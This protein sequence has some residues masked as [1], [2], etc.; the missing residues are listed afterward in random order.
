MGRQPSRPP[1]EL[2]KAAAAALSLSGVRGGE[3]GG[4]NARGEAVPILSDDGGG[5]NGGTTGRARQ[6]R[7]PALAHEAIDMGRGGVENRGTATRGGAKEN[8][9]GG[10]EGG[11]E[12]AICRSEGAVIGDAGAV[13]GEP[14]DGEGTE[15][16][17]GPEK[18]A[19]RGVLAPELPDE[20]GRD[21]IEGDA[22]ID[23]GVGG[24]ATEA[25]TP[26]SGGGRGSAPRTMGT[27]AAGEG[28]ESTHSTEPAS[29]LGV[30]LDGEEESLV[31]EALRGDWRCACRTHEIRA[32][33]CVF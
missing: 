13:G 27:E 28:V 7:G 5:V 18:E 20:R 22:R 6:M 3:L 30:K 17:A 25:G 1:E 14:G 21:L 8:S 24:K 29:E 2:R 19:G 33:L 11:A 32:H 26:L 23:G 15:V 9:R 10:N 31:V 12:A 4:G 16:L